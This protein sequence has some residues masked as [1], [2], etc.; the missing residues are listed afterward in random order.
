MY[1]IFHLKEIKIKKS[2]FFIVNSPSQ[3]IKIKH[4]FNRFQI[5]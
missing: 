3:L 1:N 4:K 5:K 2:F